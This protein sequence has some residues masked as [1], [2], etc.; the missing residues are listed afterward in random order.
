MSRK[1]LYVPKSARGFLKGGAVA[2]VAHEIFLPMS[3]AQPVRAQNVDVVP[4]WAQQAA[5]PIPI[6]HE[7]AKRLS[8]QGMSSNIIPIP[9]IPREVMREEQEYNPSILNRANF[10][11]LA[12]IISKVILD[13]L[14]GR[15]RRNE[16]WYMKAL[17]YPTQIA[18]AITTNETNGTPINKENFLTKAAPVVGTIANSFLPG[19]GTAV[20]WGMRGLNWL[21]NRFSG[22]GKG[23]KAKRRKRGK[24]MFVFNNGT[25]QYLGQKVDFEKDI[26]KVADDA[27]KNRAEDNRW[28]RIISSAFSSAIKTVAPAIGSG[29]LILGRK[30]KKSKLR[31]MAKRKGGSVKDYMAWVRSFK[32]KKRGRGKGYSGAGK[33]RR[34]RRRKRHGGKLKLYQSRG[35]YYPK[36]V[37]R[38]K[39]KRR[40]RGLVSSGH[41]MKG[42]PYDYSGMPPFF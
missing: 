14:D 33:K 13:V 23:G 37:K 17:R 18:E 22:S 28:R 6:D 38:R 40:G 36:P 2:D 12:S 5:I 26:K 4:N 7:A 16:P 31:K 9:N 19:T 39:H 42:T 21:K 30:I 11:A 15:A 1:Y 10:N 25:R 41:I 27:F 20:K 35:I 24:P 32:K 3:L 8:S 34:H 29:R